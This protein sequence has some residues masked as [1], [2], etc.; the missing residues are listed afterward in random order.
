MS[1]VGCRL[2]QDRCQLCS[3]QKKE[4]LWVP[5]WLLPWGG[6]SLLIYQIG[7]TARGPSDAQGRSSING[8]IEEVI[9][10]L[11]LPP[12][13]STLVEIPQK[14]MLQKFR[15]VATAVRNSLVVLQKVKY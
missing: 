5:N 9:Y 1:G 14:K 2:S 6:L 7:K 13:K 3:Y 12:N 11:Q 15:G 4:M 10:F 8:C